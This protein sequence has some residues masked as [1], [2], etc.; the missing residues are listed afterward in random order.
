MGTKT[1]EKP[2]ICASKMFAVFLL[3]TKIECINL[4]KQ[5][6]FAGH[7]SYVIK[8]VRNIFKYGV[9]VEVIQYLTVMI[10]F[11]LIFKVN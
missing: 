4:I 2:G 10:T 11:T 3:N 5:L 8:T 7:I 1:A 6:L 9:Y